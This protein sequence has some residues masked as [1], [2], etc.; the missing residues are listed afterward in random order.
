[1]S[2]QLI[3]QLKK[4]HAELVKSFEDIKAAGVASAEGQKKTTRHK[5]FFIGPPQN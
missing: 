3:T 4:Q 1:M 2:S 5:E